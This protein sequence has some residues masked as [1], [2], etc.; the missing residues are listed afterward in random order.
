MRSFTN[1]LVRLCLAL[2]IAVS[3][4][5]L[6][7]PRNAVAQG[8]LPV[9]RNETIF[10]EDTAVYAVF[11]S[12][13]VMIPNGNEFA[14]G[15]VQIGNE[16]LFL[17]NFATGKIEPWLGKSYEYNKDYT[18]LTVHLRDD[19]HWQ[20]GQ[21]FTADD[22]VFTAKTIMSSPKL[23]GNA[24]WTEFVKE[25]TAPDKATVKLTL[26][27]PAPRF[28][29]NII[30]DVGGFTILPKHIWEG[31]DATT[32][33]NNPPVTTS[34]WKLKQVLPDLKMFIWERDENYW[35]KKERFP[36]AKY[37]VYREAPSSTDT[38]YQDFINNTIDHAHRLADYSQFQ[39][40]QKANPAITGGP[41]Q[42][43][44]PRG[45][46]I[47][48]QKHPLSKPEVRWALSYLVNREK[49]GNVIWSPPTTPADHP[50]SDWASLA[51]FLDKSVL[52]ANKIEYDPAKAAKILDGLGFKPGA[53]GIRV[54]DKGNKMSFT[55]ITPA[56]VGAGEYQIGQ[57]VADEAKQVGIELVIKHLDGGPFDDT[58]NSGNFDITSHWLCGAWH[59]ALEL[60]QEYTSDRPIPVNGQRIPG[61]NWIGLKDP[62]L[63]DAVT[64]L[65]KL[66]PD[67]AEAKA[68]YK[69]ALE[70]WMKDM[71]AIPVIQTI[72]FMPWNQT[73]WT[74]WPVDK[75]MYTIPFTW[76]A[77]FS[78][79]PFQLKAAKK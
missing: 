50:W 17:G 77:T 14:Q 10:L 31:K 5:A 35:D 20:D 54:D 19:V 70:A 38:D 59:D 43:P 78:K 21:P 55:V 33:K 73:Y 13:N 46:W 12:F 28:H 61:G 71:P 23:G 75:N 60:Y 52:A 36:D 65:K 22:V 6:A 39:Q 67:T 2:M 37:I 18:E 7:V 26:T 9:P 47:N 16:Y 45:M 79:V 30:A 56:P 74:G 53:D 3:A 58:I 27:K 51:P 4:V 66:G 57:D 24:T 68:A 42:D 34:V 29:N 41:F 49:I 69:D 8:S 1:P 48:T 11:D 62:K 44:C 76:W 72:Y 15:F 40:S 25:A 63:D 64:R 32:F